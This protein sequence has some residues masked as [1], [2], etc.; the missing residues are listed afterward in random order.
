MLSCELPYEA[1]GRSMIGHFFAPDDQPRPAVLVFPDAGGIGEHSKARARRIAEEF[2]YAALACDLWGEGKGATDMKTALER[3]A[4]I[5]GNRERVRALS[6]PALAALADRPEV[7]IERVAAIGFC[8]GGTVSFEL[9]L[10]GANLRAA[11]GFHSGLRLSSPEDADKIKASILAMIGADDPSILPDD[12]LTFE[13]YFKATKVDWEVLVFGGVVHS[14]TNEDA[15]SFRRPDFARYD[16]R[17]DERSWR[18][19]RDF[20]EETLSR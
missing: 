6:V 16:K 20:L 3:L 2:G 19:L 8:F 14:F 13:N 1:D 9:A 7:D 18:L 5:R 17:A 12:R 10:T 15:A 4:E 11:V